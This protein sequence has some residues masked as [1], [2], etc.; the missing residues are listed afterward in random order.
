MSFKSVFINLLTVIISII[1]FCLTGEFLTRIFWDVGYHHHY[2]WSDRTIGY[3]F[4]KNKSVYRILVLGDSYAYGQGVQREE[5]LAKV[6]ENLLNGFVNDEN[7]KRF[8]NDINIKRFEVI[9]IG[10][11]GINT[12]DEYVEFVDK[13]L[14]YNPN[15]VLVAYNLNDLGAPHN[16]RLNIYGPQGPYYIRGPLNR[17]EWAWSLPIPKSVDMWLSFNSD[18]YLFIL[19]RYDSFLHK[20][21]IR[22]TTVDYDA[23]LIKSYS[24]NNEEWIMTQAALKQINYLCKQNRME[25]LIV[26]L[27]YVHTLER[28]PFSEIHTK[29]ASTAKSLCFNVLDLSPAF[30][31]KKSEDYIVS[32]IDSHPNALAHKIMAEEIFQFL[33]QKDWASDEDC[34]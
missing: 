24:E 15:A 7:I 17:K 18:F 8:V 29:V 32:R 1:V 33:K 13:G 12:A 23:E 2:D 5:T 4:E 34:K 30:I 11:P 31:G 19:R 28:Y 22:K 27:P 6:L 25:S 21:G 3:S 16:T 9:N 14:K 20:I 26:I 10:W